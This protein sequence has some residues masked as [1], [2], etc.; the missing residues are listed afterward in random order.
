M[1][2]TRQE[3]LKRWEDGLSCLSED[4]GRLES[5]PDNGRRPADLAERLRDLKVRKEELEA[6]IA[7]AR[8]ADD[9]VWEGVQSVIDGLWDGLSGK[10]DALLGRGD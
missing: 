2:E 1:A 6:K 8:D 10:L 3:C 7:E 9:A 5:L 4:I